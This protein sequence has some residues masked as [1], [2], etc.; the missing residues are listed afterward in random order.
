M[1]GSSSIATG[2]PKPFLAK[3]YK[4]VDEEDT[5]EIVAWTQAGDALIVLD[6]E[7]FAQ[8]LLPLH[9]KHNNFSSFVRQL[10]TYGF[11]KVQISRHERARTLCTGAHSA[12]DLLSAD[13]PRRMDLCAC[14]LP[15]RC[16]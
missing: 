4:M 11:S 13:R 7:A 15:P 16:I 3:L 1:E 5:N 10:N 6:P 9:F 2:Q 8:K 12:S 14:A